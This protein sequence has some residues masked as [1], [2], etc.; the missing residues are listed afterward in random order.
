MH[1]G[2]ESPD[3][4]H[5]TGH[6]EYYLGEDRGNAE[7]FAHMAIDA[8][9]SLVIASGP[10]VLRGMQFYKRHLIAYSVGNFA[11][12]GDFSTEGDLDMSV[13]LHV[14]LSPAGRFEHASIYPIQFTAEGRPVPG[15]GAIAFVA[16]LAAEDFG[17]SAARILPSGVITPP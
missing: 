5:V 15:G 1:A 2:A 11:S 13:I 16:G 7:A 10:H 6:E 8:G 14:T 12:Y 3:A 17:S 4:D 9:A